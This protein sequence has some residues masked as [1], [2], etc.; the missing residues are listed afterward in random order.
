MEV[1]EERVG[2][3]DQ[4]GGGGALG[5]GAQAACRYTEPFAFPDIDKS[6]SMSIYPQKG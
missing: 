1:G 4:V 5:G 2:G 6:F 3:R